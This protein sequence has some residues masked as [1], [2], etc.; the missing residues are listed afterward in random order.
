LRVL[1]SK[2]GFLLINEARPSWSLKPEATEDEDEDEE[3]K[4]A[5]KRYRRRYKA[6]KRER[7]GSAACGGYVRRFYERASF[8]IRK[9][10]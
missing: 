4:E 5:T 3:E 2:E 8:K 10:W 7:E 1:I 6:G 9:I